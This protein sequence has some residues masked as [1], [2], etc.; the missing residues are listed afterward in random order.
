MKELSKNE[1]EVPIGLR[2]PPGV[3]IYARISGP[4]QFMGT[5]SSS[6]VNALTE[7]ILRCPDTAKPRPGKAARDTPAPARRDT[8]CLDRPLHCPHY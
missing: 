5:A 3:A 8:R 1:G 6:A 2:I 7:L 4:F